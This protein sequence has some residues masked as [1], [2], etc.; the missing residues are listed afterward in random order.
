MVLYSCCHI[1]PEAGQCR[2]IMSS[3][4]T[5]LKAAENTKI[6]VFNE[7]H[8]TILSLGEKK[9]S[10]CTHAH[11]RERLNVSHH[12]ASPQRQWCQSTH[13]GKGF[14]MSLLF[15]GTPVNIVTVATKFQIPGP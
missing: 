7:D 4:C 14:M 2:I 13:S 8:F 10:D 3:L 12:T 1:I 9:E 5:V 11:K 6:P 15:K